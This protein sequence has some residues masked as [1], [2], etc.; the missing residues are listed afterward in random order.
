MATIAIHSYLVTKMGKAFGEAASATRTLEIR[1]DELNL[2]ND[3]RVDA[4]Q[5][6]VDGLDS[7]LDKLSDKVTVNHA[8]VFGSHGDQ[9]K[10]GMR[11]MFGVDHHL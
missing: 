1:L 3:L 2:N 9:L 7:E 5:N 4:F 8:Q 6:R 10:M 11:A